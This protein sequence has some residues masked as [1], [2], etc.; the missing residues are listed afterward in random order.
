MQLVRFSVTNYRSITKAYKLP[1]LQNTVLVGPNNEGKSNILRALV[2]SLEFLAGLG[3]IKIQRGRLLSFLRFR[4]SYD[5]SKDFPINLQTK[6]PSGESIFRLEF[7]LDSAEIAEFE[8]E[9]GSTLNGTLPIE[10]RVGQKEPGFK[11]IKRGPYARA[12]SSKAEAIA[13]F[14]SK[15]IN[16]TYIPSIR[17]A[18][19]AQDIVTEIL[20]KELA[21]VE[22]EQAY[23]D[24]IAAVEKLQ[25]PVLDRVSLSIKNTLQDFLPNVKEVRVKIPPEARRRAFRRSCEIIVDDG[26]PTNLST[27]GD[28]AQSLAALSLMRHAS[29]SGAIGKQLILAIEEPESHLHPNAIHQLRTV[30]SEIAQNHQV[31]MTTHCPLFVDRV[32]LKSNIVVHNNKA[33][34]A[35]DLRQIRDILGV[36]AADNLRNAELILV[37]EGEEDRRAVMALLK[38]HSPLLSRAISQGELAIESL[39]GASNLSYKLSQIRETLCITHSFLD[40]DRCGIDSS[41]KA[42]KE[43]LLEPVDITFTT[44]NGMAESEIEDLYSDN[45]YSNMLQNKYGVSTLSPKF[46][47][48]SKWSKRLEKT[49]NNAGKHWSD[50]IKSKVKF[51]VSELVANDPGSALNTHKR[52]SFDAL[53]DALEKKLKKIAQNKK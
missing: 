5:W 18:G 41:E 6:F 24:A 36:R 51:D 4:E 26:T 38:H 47:G 43:G 9:I 22:V 7:K 21:I 29:E 30:L 49:F 53:V 39:L 13:K 44:C 1:V 3:D 10:L 32:S 35:K 14:V 50:G 31:I 40:H 23:K 2:T 27:K 17:T 42:E 8:S 46:R 45:I 15:R 12:L 28:G 48:N 16:I 11:V 20:E 52:A 37:V 25:Q 33:A 19:A 34:P